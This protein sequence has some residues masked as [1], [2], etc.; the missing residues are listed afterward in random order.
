MRITANAQS[1]TAKNIRG[2]SLAWRA[3]SEVILLP[4]ES[5]YRDFIEASN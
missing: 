5:T 1:A 2:V 4:L 3:V